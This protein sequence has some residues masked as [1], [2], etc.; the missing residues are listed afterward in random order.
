MFLNKM[1]NKNITVEEYQVRVNAWKDN[2]M[3]F[4]KIFLSGIII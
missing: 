2:N 1:K 4:L 3:N